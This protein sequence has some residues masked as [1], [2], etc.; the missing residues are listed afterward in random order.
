MFGQP[1]L[2]VLAVAMAA[3]H[4]QGHSPGRGCWPWMRAMAAG[5]GCAPLNT[6]R[7]GTILEHSTGGN[8]GLFSP[9][10]FWTL[11]TMFVFGLPFKRGKRWPFFPGGVL[12]VGK[13]MYYACGCDAAPLS[14]P[15]PFL[16]I[17]KGDRLFS[18]PRALNYHRKRTIS[19]KLQ[20]INSFPGV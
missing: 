5:H 18:G 8:A 1:W 13:H 16:A 14:I 12:D 6:L 19:Q 17:H 3:G 7:P 20:T 9:R 4:G 11:G 2:P 15:E 10:R